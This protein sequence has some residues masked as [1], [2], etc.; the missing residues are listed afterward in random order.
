MLVY[1]CLLKCVCVCA[2]SERPHACIKGRGSVRGSDRYVQI[3]S[4]LEAL[5]LQRHSVICALPAG[6]STANI[7]QP[8]KRNMFQ[9]RVGNRTDRKQPPE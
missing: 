8:E 5:R 7:L 9:F 4:Y 3:I 1:I 6:H 2:C